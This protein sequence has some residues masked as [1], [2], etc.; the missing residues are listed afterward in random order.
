MA[1]ET[2]TKPKINFS[3]D[4]VKKAAKL[5]EGQGYIT[6]LDFPEMKDYEWTKQFEQAVDKTFQDS[7]DDPYLYYERFDFVGGDIDSIIFNM[8]I[9][10]S[11]ELALEKLAEVLKEKIE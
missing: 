1:E 4:Q 8:D 11:R 10:K 3:G 9:I 2:A 6:K 7:K 5:L